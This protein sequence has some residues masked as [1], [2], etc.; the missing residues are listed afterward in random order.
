RDGLRQNKNSL[1]LPLFSKKLR[2]KRSKTQKGRN[3][4][5]DLFVF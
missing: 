4:N 3:M 1:F 5:S 2:I